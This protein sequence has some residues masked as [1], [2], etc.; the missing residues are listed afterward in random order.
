[1]TPHVKKLIGAVL[2]LFWL[3]LYALI[4][5]GLA[6]HV[7]PRANWYDSLLFY[8]ATGLIWIVPIGLALPWMYAEP[9]GKVDEA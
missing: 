7:L 6:I 3:A 4:V 9:K 1:M 8:G 2:I 5:S